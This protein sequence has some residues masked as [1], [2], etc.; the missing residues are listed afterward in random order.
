[1]VIGNDMMYFT[2]IENGNIVDCIPLAEIMQL[3][4]IGEGNHEGLQQITN[5]SSSGYDLNERSSD[6]ILRIDTNADGYNSGRTYY[7]QISSEGEFSRLA[8][9]L[10]AYVAIA[11]KRL[12]TKTVLERSQKK[13]RNVFHSRAF[14]FAASF[15]ILAVRHQ[16]CCLLKWKL[17]MAAFT[18]VIE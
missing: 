18:F 9:S 2:L 10:T 15:F 8:I 14:Q 11:S 12:E 3:K 1:M 4:K 16:L 17:W 7:L 6:R 13:V 5:M